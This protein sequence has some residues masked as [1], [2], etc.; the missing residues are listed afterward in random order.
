MSE[1]GAITV[2]QL[3][4]YA[5]SLLEG[6][7]NLKNITVEGEI[8]G[9]V[10]NSRSGHAYF[11]LK[12]EF[13][14]VRTV[15]FASNFATLSFMPENGMKVLVRGKVSLY[16]R[17]GQFQ[18]NAVRMT[19]SG[20]GDC[21]AE[22]LR[23]KEKLDKEGL[24]SSEYKKPLP[25]YPRNIGLITSPTGA[26]LQD[27]IN[28]TKKRFP[29]VVLSVY[30]AAMQGENTVD[31]VISGLD[32]FD[33]N[34]VDLIVITRGGGNYEDLAVFNDERL[35]RR[36]FCERIPVVSAIGHEIDYTALDF[37]ADLR[38][39]TP[40]AAAE[41]VT[42]DITAERYSVLS[43]GKRIENGM[44]NLLERQKAI[45]RAAES[46]IDMSKRLASE[47]QRLDGLYS[48]ITAAENSAVRAEKIK[49]SGLAEKINAL[50]PLS[51]LSRGFA[52]ALKDEKPLRSVSEV[53]TGDRLS[54]KLKD[55]VI[56]CAAEK[57]R[58]ENL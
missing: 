3:N 22:F 52:V 40:S 12:D 33:K 54:V 39:P 1:T 49:L 18:L 11:T 44:K 16:E 42:P 38:A 4:F 10:L 19:E 23:L 5:K 32:F 36:V 26:A 56:D 9:F 27:F 21:Y 20:I 47:N 43:L 37:V 41:T 6:D 55:G 28:V 48:R 50:N 25:R 34:P 7:R 30:P 53:K 2:R 13:C 58:T 31:D 17:D 29:S 51:V 45:L 14:Q 57:I 24:F 35:A 15:M 46:G 8:S